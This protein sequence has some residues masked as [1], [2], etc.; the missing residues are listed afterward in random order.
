MKIGIIEYGM[1]NV[2][3]VANAFAVL[4]AEPIIAHDPEDLRGADAVVLPGVG[5]FGDGIRNLRERGWAEVLEEEVR[6]RSKPFLGLCLGMHLIADE[7][8]EHGRVPGL[9]WIHGTVDRLRSDQTGLRVPHIGWNDVTFAA[10]TRLFHGL[11]QP[12]A[13]YFAHS[14]A[15]HGDGAFVTAECDYGDRFAAGIEQNNVAA[16]QF[17]PEKS[18]RLGLAV[19]R[20]FLEQFCGARA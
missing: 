5:A 19:L 11:A 18:H 17:H 6:G 4:G 16:T 10:E 7:G 15:L 12:A 3:S 1:G 20:N 9:G 14:Y 2:T 8:T 13:F